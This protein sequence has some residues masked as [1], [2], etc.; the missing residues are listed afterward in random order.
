MDIQTQ[1]SNDKDETLTC[2]FCDWSG[3]KELAIIDDGDILCPACDNTILHDDL[4]IIS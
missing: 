1:L 3:L 2:K 4:L